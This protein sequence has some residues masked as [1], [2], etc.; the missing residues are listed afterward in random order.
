[1]KKFT[2]L[3]SKA[4]IVGIL[5]VGLFK[6]Y[7]LYKQNLLSKDSFLIKTTVVEKPFVILVSAYNPG[8]AYKKNIYSILTQEYQ[9]FR[10]LYL[11]DNSTD[12]SP[13]ELQQVVSHLEKENKIT[14]ISNKSSQGALVN[15]HKAIESCSDEE[16]VLVIDALD[17]LA[18][19]HVLTKLNR[20]YSN[21]FTW[22]TYGSFLDYPSYKHLPLQCKQIP[23]NV[24]FNNSYRSHD[25]GDLHP[26]T[27]YAGLFKQIH[28]DDLYLA[29]GNLAY[30]LPLLEMSGKHARFVADIFSLHRRAVDQRKKVDDA[31]F[32]M[33]SLKKQSK[34]KRL[35]SLPLHQN[36]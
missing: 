7:A 1:M 15:I 33:A 13:F 9:N 8:N 29:E 18:H 5:G 4:F 22:M 11:D 17:F 26:L 12:G 31:A 14:L 35:K 23:K 27:F 10:V 19:E 34:Y 24:V 3:L 21:P 2:K 30:A 28:P 25:I 20:L 32:D 36:P 16:I 6:S